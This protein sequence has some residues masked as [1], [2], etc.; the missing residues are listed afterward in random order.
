[1][2][3]PPPRRAGWFP[4]HSSYESDE[5]KAAL[6]TIE[7]VILAHASEGLNVSSL[8]YQTGIRTALD[9]I[10]NRYYSGVSDWYPYGVRCH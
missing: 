9:A 2:A 1:M 10:E 4:C 5:E 8:E 7:S 6:D 3:I